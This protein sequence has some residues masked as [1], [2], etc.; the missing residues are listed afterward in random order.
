MEQRDLDVFLTSDAWDLSFFFVHRVFFRDRR[1]EGV[2][3][4]HSICS[5]GG[6]LSNRGMSWDACHEAKTVTIRP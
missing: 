2:T 4:A 3:L 5:Q 6:L 1:S